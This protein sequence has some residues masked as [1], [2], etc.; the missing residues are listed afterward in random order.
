MDLKTD[1]Q[2]DRNSIIM[3]V[4]VLHVK[5]TIVSSTL[6]QIK[7]TSKFKLRS[8]VSK[9]KFNLPYNVHKTRAG[10]YYPFLWML[11]DA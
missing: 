5:N 10:G 4:Y 2:G 9:I 1:G 11:T 6:V 8:L 3:R 7:Q